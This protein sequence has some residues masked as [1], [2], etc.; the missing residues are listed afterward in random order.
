MKRSRVALV[1]VVQFGI[2][3]AAL[4][5]LPAV[6]EAQ[7]W[8]LKDVRRTDAERVEGRGNDFIEYN[9][10]ISFS[11]PETVTIGDSFNISVSV[12][13]NYG[14][15]EGGANNGRPKRLGI[16]ISLPNGGGRE[17]WDLVP[18]Y[19]NDRSP[20]RPDPMSKGG[21]V[22]LD[23]GGRLTEDDA[24][25]RSF[26]IGASVS[27][28]IY[29]WETEASGSAG[30]VAVYERVE[31][32]A[33]AGVSSDTN[34]PPRVSISVRDPDRV[35]TPGQKTILKARVRDD[36]DRPSQMTYAWRVTNQTTGRVRTSRAAPGKRTVRLTVGQAATYTIDLAV[37][38]RDGA[39]GTASRDITSEDPN[40]L[41][42]AVSRDSQEEVSVAN[43]WKNGISASRRGD[44]F[45]MNAVLEHYNRRLHCLRVYVDDKRVTR[46]PL[47]PDGWR[48][49]LLGFDDANVRLLM[50]VPADVA[51]G[52]H[53]VELALNRREE[54]E[55]DICELEISREPLPDELTVLFNPFGD[56]PRPDASVVAGKPIA[57]PG[58]DHSAA[59]AAYTLNRW[60]T[61]YIPAGNTTS[62]NQYDV[63][64]WAPATHQVAM[65]IVGALQDP[66]R[67][68]AADVAKALT[69][70]AGRIIHGRWARNSCYMP[71]GDVFSVPTRAD[72][73]AAGGV[74]NYDD[75]TSPGRWRSAEEIFQEFLRTGQTVRYG[76]CFVFGMTLSAL[77]R[78]VGIPARM[79]SV[80]GSTHDSSEP[81]GV[82][83]LDSDKNNKNIGYEIWNFHV[84]VEAWIPEA[85]TASGW[86]LID[87]T[88]QG[89]AGGPS[90][91]SFVAVPGLDQVKAVRHLPLPQQYPDG[92]DSV[93]VF[94]E[95][96]LPGAEVT[97]DCVSP[98]SDP[99]APR[100]NPRRIVADSD[101]FMRCFNDRGANPPY[102]AILDCLISGRAASKGWVDDPA[103][104]GL[105][106]LPPYKVPRGV[107]PRYASLAPAAGSQNAGGGFVPA[108]LGMLS[109]R[110]AFAQEEGQVSVQIDFPDEVELSRGV[111]GRVEFRDLPDDV[112]VGLIIRVRYLPSS[113][114]G[115]AT[116]A[117]VEPVMVHS[118]RRPVTPSGRQWSGEFEIPASALS[119]AGSYLLTVGLN[120]TAG[121]M[122]QLH[123]QVNGPP[124]SLEVGQDVEVGA[125]FFIRA[126]LA[127]PMT[128]SIADAR[129][130]VFLSS[131]LETTDSTVAGPRELA[132]GDSLELEITARATEPGRHLVQA[133]ADGS[134]GPSRAAVEV[135]ATSAEEELAVR[136]ISVTD[137]AAG[138][139]VE[140]SAE[141]GNPRV[142]ELGAVQATLVAAEGVEILSDATISVD[143]ISAQGH[144]RPVWTVRAASIGSYRMSVEATAGNIAGAGT[145]SLL[146]GA[147]DADELPMPAEEEITV[148]LDEGEDPNDP[149]LVPI[150]MDT[151]GG[152]SGGPAAASPG[153][154]A[155]GGGGR[156][157]RALSSSGPAWA[158]PLAIF[159]AIGSLALIGAIGYTLTRRSRAGAALPAPPAPVSGGP[160]RYVS[161]KVTYEDGGTK[162]GRL[163]VTKRATV[164]RSSQSDLTLNDPTVSARHAQLAWSDE[165][166]VLTD[167]GSTSDT[168]VNGK[169]VTRAVVGAGD[170]ILLGSTRVLIGE[171]SSD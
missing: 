103:G 45:E 47:H 10:S 125:E 42:F 29:C 43:Y 108:I 39:V 150:D 4:V 35:L 148:P 8:K 87:A 162:A 99:S 109:P 65:Q 116:G 145:I 41:E 130:E 15:G 64:P 161:V 153:G 124:V 120:G 27:A 115:G 131:G 72:C 62:P 106:H 28:G 5:L 21:S 135:F 95:T 97:L 141:I 46:Q 54:P 142:R 51:I 123:F 9:P 147:A 6:A 73:N 50:Q 107:F 79:I 149:S 169:Q 159:L 19:C 26:S 60:D 167:L 136:G 157:G 146:V 58:F 111:T 114:T 132:A 34:Q 151:D 22:Q 117:G 2:L 89:R 67:A 76:Q 80:A 139:E 98:C 24:E 85:N 164:G 138:A 23:A 94:T 13:Y 48:A 166:L 18:D 154:G 12:S 156:G 168:F 36:R 55:S 86:V 44:R 14:A 92:D 81:W 122:D 101:D 69:E 121:A 143:N 25:R 33:E 133:M 31:D 144:G 90:A 88:Q 17:S 113:L 96:N 52:E 119:S 3:C 158:I 93:F 104:N 16:S 40:I 100:S 84:W 127:N 32:D 105:D 134:L 37:R 129:L 152:V 56:A 74:W 75:G 61:N 112:P 71:D 137:A 102:G 1:S 165:G 38:D 170:E 30:V 66:A 163:E 57:V 160:R 20:D 11:P 118:E 63:T 7:T 49:A 53:T 59:A 140:V 82:G 128:E 171:V 68:R 77:L 91:D 70:G 78:S 110:S 155:G 83:N 126:E